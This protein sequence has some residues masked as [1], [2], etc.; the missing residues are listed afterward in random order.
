[1]KKLFACLMIFIACMMPI[2]G[3]FLDRKYD[4]THNQTVPVSLSI[5]ITMCSLIAMGIDIYNKE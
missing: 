4:F 3:V 5:I 2:I 1:M